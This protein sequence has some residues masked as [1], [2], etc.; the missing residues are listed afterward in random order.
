VYGEN[1][2]EFP[3]ESEM[4]HL[5]KFC[6]SLQKQR[7]SYLE[8]LILNGFGLYSFNPQ[9]YLW[10]GTESK[11]VASSM[12]SHTSISYICGLE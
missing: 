2:G 9:K 8:H 3:E 7:T 11:M 12:L 4:R 6:S 5:G 1:K 10:K